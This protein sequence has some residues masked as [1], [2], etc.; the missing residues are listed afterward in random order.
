MKK[1]TLTTI[2]ALLAIAILAQAPQGISHQAV[3]RDASNQLVTESPIGIQISI[4]Q[5]TPEGTIVYSET[6]LPTSNTNGLISFII[7][8]GTVVSGIFSEIDWSNGP[9]F[10]KTEAD[11]AGGTNYTIVGISQLFSVPYALLSANGIMSMT[12]EQR[13]ALQNPRTGMH[14]YNI[15][16]NCLNYFNGT[17]WFEL[18]G[19]CT[20]MPNQANAGPDQYFADGTTSILLEGNEPVYSTGSWTI[21]SGDGG[22]LNDP[23]DP[24]TLFTGLPGN[25]YTLKWTI[26][27]S[28]GST[29]DLVIIIFGSLPAVTTAEVSNIAANSATGGGN[30]TDDGAAEVTAKGVVWSTTENP[31]IETNEGMTNDGSGIGVFTSTLTSLIPE[32]TYFIRAYATNSV[33]TAYGYEL[34]FTTNPAVLRQNVVVEI[35]TGTW[36]SFDPGAAMGADDLLS[37]GHVVAVIKYHNGDV[38]ANTA[39]DSRIS[40]YNI[41]GYPTAKFDGVLTF[42]GGS[43]NQSLYPNYLPLYQQR[44]AIPSSFLIDIAGTSTGND[45]SIVLTIEKVSAY[46]G[47]DIVVHLVLTES[48]IPFAWQ[49]QT[50]VNQATRLMAPD[51][52]GT[53]LDFYNGDIQT[54]NISFTVNAAWIYDLEL[55][56]FIQDNATKEILQGNKVM[57]NNL[58]APTP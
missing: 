58:Q 4:I 55:V 17:S 54:V 13:D 32:T 52:N 50:H 14:I 40:Y 11:P 7:G 51:H 34:S 2:Y 47:T 5:G 1:I 24:N 30:V 57:L 3:I 41:T 56:A 39:S 6:H 8:Q 23:N 28:C 27:N 43:P 48:N 29:E 19:N 18:C 42:L 10:I 38:F 12:L 31:T 49:N 9:Y 22:Y 33:G 20:P 16:S 46:T 25:D 45:Y 53:A 26:Y 21:V 15:T 36:S 37:N 44:E 35:G